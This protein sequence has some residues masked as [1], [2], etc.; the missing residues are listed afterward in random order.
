MVA[1]TDERCRP[2]VAQFEQLY[3]Q[4]RQPVVNV[5]RRF[6]AAGIDPEV[7]AQEAFV[8]AWRSWG[9]FAAERPFGPWVV[10]I[11]RRLC[12]NE[13]HT[14][15]RRNRVPQ[16][17]ASTRAEAEVVDLTVRRQAVATTLRLL[18]PRHRRVLCLRDL[19]GWSYEQIATI[20]DTTVEAVRGALRRAR[21]EFRR[22]YDIA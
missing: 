16:P 6:V 20:D 19:E 14:A 18:S 4:W 8:R 11:A 13:F 5:C 3:R 22:L 21:A 10:T 9:R 15:A 17:V 7:V 12:I 1:R 2:D